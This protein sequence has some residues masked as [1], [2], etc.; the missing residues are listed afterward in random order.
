MRGGRGWECAQILQDQWLVPS[1]SSLSVWGCSPLR[2]RTIAGRVSPLS[3]GLT[4]LLPSPPCSDPRSI[5]TPVVPILP[6]TGHVHHP[7]LWVERARGRPWSGRYVPADGECAR[8]ERRPSKSMRHICGEDAWTKERTRVRDDQG[9]WTLGM[10]SQN[11]FECARRCLGVDEETTCLYVASHPQRFRHPD[12]QPC[13]S[14][15]IDTP[16]IHSRPHTLPQPHPCSLSQSLNSKEPYARVGTAIMRGRH[17]MML[18]SDLIFQQSP[19]EC[20]SG[21]ASQLASGRR[22]MLWGRGKRPSMQ[23]ELS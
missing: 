14:P 19:R 9:R 20:L 13:P 21:R 17:E 22:T 4:P 10:R 7:R 11:G 12:P 23:R 6:T 1:T 15:P 18:G 8:L 2:T 3:V 5:F 16:L